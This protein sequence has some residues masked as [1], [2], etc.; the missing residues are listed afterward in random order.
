MCGIT[1]I[2]SKNTV[3]KFIL[4]SLKQLQNRGYDSA[5]IT[6][7]NDDGFNTIRF[8]S[9]YKQSAMSQIEDK[10]DSL[11]DSTIG[12]GHTR[13]ATHGSKTDENSHP[14]KS[15]KGK[16]ILAHNGII[17]N[18]RQLKSNL[19]KKGYVFESQ[20]DTE[21]IVN[22]LEYEYMICHDV[23]KA[24]KNTLNKLEGTWGLVILCIDTP[25]IIYA[26]RHGS[27]LLVSTNEKYG[28]ITSEQS[29]F[30][31]LTNNYIILENNDICK[32]R[33]SDNN[34]VVDTDYQYI[35][36]K[37]NGS[38]FISTPEP[39]SHWTIKEIY[40]QQESSLR[41]INLGGRLLDTNHVRLGG[42]TDHTEELMKMNNLII[43]GCGTSY[44]AGMIGIKYFKELCDFNTVQLIDGAEFNIHDVP[45]MGTTLLIFL[46]QSGETH[47]LQRCISIGKENELYMLG[48]VNVVDSLIAREVNCG[49]YLNAGREV[50]V[51]STKSFTSQVI[52]LSMIA[53]WFSQNKSICKIK[54]EKI[55]SDLRKLHLDISGTIKISETECH[56]YVNILNK[57]S[58]FILGKGRGEAIAHEGSLKIKELSY[59]H[60]EGYASSSLKHGPFALLDPD[61]PVIIIAPDNNVYSKNMN[62]YEEITS[63]NS[64]VIMITDNH[65]CPAQNKIILPK[66][67]SFAELLAVIPLQFFA[68]Q[69]AYERG[70]PI[71]FPRSLAKCVTV[72]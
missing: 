9:T 36:K 63:R 31:G 49:C 65:N 61:V 5:G 26:V 69:L 2:L 23:I 58:M 18:Y 35:E 41:A 15:Y 38:D 30:C 55:I 10:L 52:L 48:V 20:T 60:A 71:D 67:D 37:I 16:F 57:Q 66:N 43:L 12:I 64:P 46:S 1:A 29:G 47:D 14:H 17:E 53:I 8:A 59:I 44:N 72:G 24:I 25:N 56:N 6:T 28:I 11:A 40:E 34:I 45:K 33:L 42:L 62:A 3:K 19:H 70:H 54:R 50:G 39:Y 7:V 4:D 27:P 68:F 51:A 21:V 22:Q 32:I 13:W